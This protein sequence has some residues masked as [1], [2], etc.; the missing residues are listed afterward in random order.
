MDG[1]YSPEIEIQLLKEMIRIMVPHMPK[2]FHD[3]LNARD[4]HLKDFIPEHPTKHLHFKV[5]LD[6]EAG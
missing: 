5:K 2:S 1:K 4:D 3:E 6:P